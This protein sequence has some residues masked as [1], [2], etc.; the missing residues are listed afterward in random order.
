MPSN[1]S[2]N[3][4]GLSANNAI[5]T[6]TA[7]YTTYSYNYSNQNY[8]LKGLN[9]NLSSSQS[10]AS[11]VLAVNNYSAV[12]Y[13]NN[14][15]SL[16]LLNLENKT[17]TNVAKIPKLDYDYL[18]YNGVYYALMPYY[19]SQNILTR[20]SSYGYYG[21]SMQFWSYNILTSVVTNQSLHFNVSASS[22]FQINY[23][24]HNYISI[25]NSSGL[26]HIYNLAT[27]SIISSIT[28]SDFEAN[29]IYY[30]PA[31]K[32][33]I[34]IQ[35]GGSS[36]DNAC[37]LTVHNDIVKLI[38][39]IKYS[40]ASVVVN[41]VPD[42]LVNFANNEIYGQTQ[43][44][45]SSIWGYNLIFKYSSGNFTLVSATALSNPKGNGFLDYSTDNGYIPLYTKDGFTA[46]HRPGYGLS[47]SIFLNPF[48]LKAINSTSGFPNYKFDTFHSSDGWGSTN[49]IPDF[50]SDVNNNTDYSYYYNLTTKV[51][52]YVWKSSTTEFYKFIPPTLANIEFVGLF[53]K[54]NLSS[55]NV[56]LS[57]NGT[58][59]NF[60]LY[61]YPTNI[62]FPVMSII[63]ITVNSPSYK[64]QISYIPNI[65][66]TPNSI[67]NIY[68]NN[69]PKVGFLLVV[70]SN[71][72]SYS[73]S[74]TSNNITYSTYNSNNN[75]YLL[76]LTLDYYTIIFNHKIGY[77]NINKVSF[78]LNKNT[79][80][81]NNYSIASFTVDFINNNSVPVHFTINNKEYSLQA[82]S[83]VNITLDYGTYFIIFDISS[84]YMVSSSTTL[85]AHSNQ[86]YI[87]TVHKNNMS[88]ILS[89]LPL[90]IIFVFIIGFF[91]L[92]LIVKTRH[93]EG[94]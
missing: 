44:S 8:T 4:S 70:K 40:T 74:I 52:T 48:T 50:Y 55:V 77:N 66:L 61:H 35:A 29:N 57:V 30:V 28:L 65:I 86:S 79:F 12:Y 54:V 78:L 76:N 25:T 73:F 27:S 47:P 45:S 13:I 36:A 32:S 63:N 93:N 68:I 3:H 37:F 33:F 46:T 26:M 92:L 31:F 85:V 34:N 53:N 83:S 15:Y 51:L 21:N 58:F 2:V 41:G 19:N 59:S 82:S 88:F 10:F 9:I 24:G 62:T 49:I 84:N 39:T 6:A 71:F 64:F 23:L 18:S 20:I 72:N 87:I 16:I 90:I 43:G 91:A 17:Y 69:T 94:F 7:G 42:I 22:N 56:I 11:E 60:T 81:Y 38:K 67:E 5:V 80:I 75:E 14:N 1:S 89:N